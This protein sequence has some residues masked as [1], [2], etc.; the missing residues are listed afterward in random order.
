MHVANIRSTCIYICIYTCIYIY[1]INLSLGHL[2]LQMQENI[3]YR[4]II[5]SNQSPNKGG[6]GPK[7]PKRINRIVC[8]YIVLVLFTLFPGWESYFLTYVLTIDVFCP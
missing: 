4:P 3:P 6:C 7:S 8:H 2:K 5:S 1:T